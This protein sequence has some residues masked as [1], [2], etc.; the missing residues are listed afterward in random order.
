MGNKPLISIIVPVYNVERYLSECLDSILSQTFT[1]FE[2]IAVD[3]GSSDNCGKILDE[4]SQKDKRIKVIHK[5]NGGVSSARNVG[6]DMASGEYVGFVDPDDKIFPDMYEQLYNEAV[7]GDYDIVQCGCVKI[8]ES[9]EVVSY[10]A[11]NEE[12]IYT[13]VD[14]ALCALFEQVI[15]NSVWSKMY[16]SDVIKNVRFMHELRV[17]EDG[18]FVHNCLMKAQRVKIINKCYYSYLVSD[19]S[20]THSKVSEKVFDNLKVLDMMN[21]LHRENEY[22]LK[23]FKKY[24]AWLTLNVAFKILGSKMFESEVADVTRRIVELKDVILKG[25]FSKKEK[26]FAVLVGIAPKITCRMVSRY[27]KK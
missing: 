16:K 14:E 25:K 4:Y 18:L 5:E 13:N 8:N 17:A 19:S 24:S 10:I 6:L 22:V 20:V 11:C 15:I 26:V 23:A 21:D 27:L 12:R 3:D 2:I 7:T 1:D 9:G